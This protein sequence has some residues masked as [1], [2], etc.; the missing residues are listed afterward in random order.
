L[1]VVAGGKIYQDLVGEEIGSIKHNMTGILRSHPV[2]S[3]VLKKESKLSEIFGTK[4]IQVNSFNHQAVKEVGEGFHVA[5]TAIYGIIEAIENEG[6][7]FVCVVQGHP[8]MMFPSVNA[9][10]NLLRLSLLIVRTNE[11]IC[12]GDICK[13]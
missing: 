9:I 5:A 1:N 8:E 2:H 6:D 7:R 3:V 13:G 12:F 10:F 4:E 11:S